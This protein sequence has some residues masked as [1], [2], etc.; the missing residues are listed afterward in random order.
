MDN[1]DEIMRTVLIGSLV[2]SFLVNTSRVLVA[3]ELCQECLILL[4]NTGQEKV[5]YACI[6]LVMSNAYCLLNDHRR[7]IECTRKLLDFLRGL[8]LRA[9]EGMA[10]SLLGKFYQL[11]SKYKEAK[12]LYEKSLNITIE[13]GDRK[14]E[15]LCYRNL[16]NVYQSLTEYRKAEEYQRKALAIT[17]E[18]DDKEGE[19][20]CYGNLGTVYFSLNEYRKAEEYLR[21]SLST[22]KEIGDREGKALCYG[23]LGT[24]YQSLGDYGK[25]E[26]YQRKALAIRKDTGDKRGEAACYGNLAIVHDTLGESGKAEEY[27]RKALSISKKTGDKQEEA[28]CYENLGGVYKSLG[29]YEKSEEYQGKALAISKEIGD[30]KGEIAS[31]LKLGN[32]YE[33]LGEYGEAEECIRKAL[34]I[35]KEIGAKKGEAA[36]YGNLGTLCRSLGKHP[37]AKEHYDKALAMSREIS[38]I[39]AEAECHLHLAYNTILEENVCLEHEIV[40]HLLASIDKCEKMRSFLGRNDQFKISLLDQHRSSYVLLSAFFCG[41]GNAKEALCVLELGRGRALADLIS[42]L[43]SAQQQT[44]LSPPSWAAIERIVKKESNCTCLYISYFGQ[45]MFLWVLKENKSIHFR[46]VNVN[47]CF[48]TKGLEREVHEVFSEENFRRFNFLPHEHCEDRSLLFL[49]ASD[50]TRELAEEGSLAAYRPVEEEE[51]ENLEALPTRAERYRM[52]IAPVA[53]FLVQPELVI[54]P[55]RELLKVPFAA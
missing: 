28:V 41:T 53:D 22:R 44:T 4:N 18:I 50:S 20:A 55:D 2:A 17:K 10:N 46:K 21:K 6:Y 5:V 7:G 52:I 32:V 35:S 15:A 23:N 37:E 31:Y 27:L 19:A 54:V 3:I 1:T 9:E 49:K 11:Q 47:E 8:G 29:K 33:T 42:G 38:D 45:C 36:C 16:G 26:K 30:K 39:R 14:E 40:S 51:E 24:V 12:G 34:V 43:H 13:T 48:V 25:A